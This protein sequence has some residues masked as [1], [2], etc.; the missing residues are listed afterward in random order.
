MLSFEW[1]EFEAVAE[2]LVA[3]RRQ[4]ADALMQSALHHG[5][6]AAL[7]KEID[8]VRRVRD[9]PL[10]HITTRLGSAASE[11]RPPPNQP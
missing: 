9:Q 8:D 11:R 10:A 4:Y 5:L 7:R 6:V 2:R 1:R 3:L